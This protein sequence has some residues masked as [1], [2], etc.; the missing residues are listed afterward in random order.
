M[1]IP[2]FPFSQKC[3]KHCFL[4]G[5]VM[6][7]LGLP[8]LGL[9]EDDSEYVGETNQAIKKV[10]IS[11]FFQ[12]LGKDSTTGFD[13]VLDVELQKANTFGGA[14]G[15][16]FH[17]YFGMETSL[18]FGK[19]ELDFEAFGVSG[20]VDTNLVGLDAN[21]NVYLYRGLIQPV[22]T[23]GIGVI[24]FLGDEAGVDF[25]ETDVSFNL[26]AGLIVNF[27]ESF[28]LKGE[29]RRYFVKLEDSDSSL[30]LNSLRAA[31]GFRF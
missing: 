18:W 6:M 20:S 19:S 2:F 25:D 27:T 11:G 30:K 31:V 17:K 14:F 23:A 15:I 24:R 5:A 22:L 10:W 28:F 9:A 12:P 29:V 26:G 3:F 4:V 16:D 8:T 13:G 1:S 7:L 21:A